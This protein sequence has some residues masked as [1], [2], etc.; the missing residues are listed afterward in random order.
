MKREVI[1]TKCSRLTLHVNQSVAE[2]STSHMQAF[3]GAF[4]ITCTLILLISL[5]DEAHQALK[6]VL[7][8]LIWCYKSSRPRE[9]P[10]CSPLPASPLQQLQ[11][12]P[13]HLH[14]L[15]GWHFLRM[16]EFTSHVHSHHHSPT[17]LSF[18]E[19]GDYLTCL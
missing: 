13:L 8:L 16:G 11:G 15:L 7:E 18:C 12:R 17:R 19:A 14:R 10:P 3:F 9:I 2:I 4:P 5:C 6:P 1:L